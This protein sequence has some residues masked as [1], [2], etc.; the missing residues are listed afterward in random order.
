[1]N[2]LLTSTSFIDTP[3]LHHE[4]LNAQKFTV[5]KLRGPVTEQELLRVIDQYD[6]IICGDDHFTEPVI[7][8]GAA[9]KLKIISKYGV[10]IDSIDTE[11]AKKYNVIVTNC[12][13]V[14]QISVAEH[15]FG[16]LLCYFRN[17]HTEYNITK[18]GGWKRLT[19]EELYG[20]TIG[21]VGLGSVGKEVALRAVSWGLR[22]VAY[23]K[24][25]D[26]NFAERYSVILKEN[27][28]DLL[29]MSDIVT[30]HLPLTCETQNIISAF[31]IA[32]VLKKGAIIVNTARAKLIDQQALLNGLNKKIVGAYLTDVMDIEPMPPEHPLLKYENVII[33]PHI[34]SRTLQAVERQ[35]VMA[36]ENLVKYLKR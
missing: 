13:G 29:A 4:L 16:L 3:G 27:L 24:N 21:I 23:E 11:A 28:D 36:V 7:K 8:K 25:P 6:G 31:R 5:D 12:S 26:K 14:N 19:G 30:L 32:N 2:I 18:Q 15:V 20:K 22:A 10:G 33:T 17:I 34:G 9:S 35:G 1:V